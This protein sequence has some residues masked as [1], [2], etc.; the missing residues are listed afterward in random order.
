MWEKPV[1]CQE[2]RAWHAGVGNRM[3]FYRTA[4]YLTT[5][6]NYK[7]Y[8]RFLDTWLLPG[9][10]PIPGSRLHEALCVMRGDG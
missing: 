5:R 1:S 4:G 8:C 6:E 9:W 10:R 7:E 3:T 2:I